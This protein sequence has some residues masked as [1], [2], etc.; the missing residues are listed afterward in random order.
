VARTRKGKRDGGAI[1]ESLD[2][3]VTGE[4]RERNTLINDLR[5]E[6]ERWRA[7]DYERAA[8]ISRKLMQH[9]VQVINHCGDQCS[10]RLTLRRE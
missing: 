2:F 1:Q 3:D 4:R 5:R 6:V 8:P 9:W 7:R 10:Q